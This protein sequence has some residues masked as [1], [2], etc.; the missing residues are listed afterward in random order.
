MVPCKKTKYDGKEEGRFKN[1]IE[2]V[3]AG[4]RLLEGDENRLLV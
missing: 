4:L 3:R 1:A 2:V